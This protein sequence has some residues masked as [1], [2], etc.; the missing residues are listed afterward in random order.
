MVKGMGSYGH[1]SVC[2]VIVVVLWTCAKDVREQARRFAQA[3]KAS[4]IFSS[5]S[6]SIN[7]QKV[8]CPSQSHKTW[9]TNSKQIFK[10]VLS[11][12]F[13]LKCTIPEV[14]NIGEPLLLYQTVA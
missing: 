14:E 9:H 4:L 13:D 5:T 7:V 6:H 12:A 3:M 2:R 11:K 10:I 8:R 1:G